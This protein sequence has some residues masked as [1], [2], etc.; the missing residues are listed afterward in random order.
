MTDIIVAVALGAAVA[1]A[2]GAAV[3]LAV[4]AAVALADAVGTGVIALVGSGVTVVVAVVEDTGVGAWPGSTT[5]RVIT[6]GAFMQMKTGSNRFTVC[7]SLACGNWGEKPWKDWAA[8]LY[9][10]IARI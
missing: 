2:V 9:R 5:G 6:P 3:A 7:R 8:L 10:Q 1:L 4:G